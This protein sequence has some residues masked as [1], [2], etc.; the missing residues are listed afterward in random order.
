MALDYYNDRRTRA[1]YYPGMTEQEIKEDLDGIRIR[2]EMSGEP[3]IWALCNLFKQKVTLH[4]QFNVDTY[5]IIG[6]EGKYHLDHR[7]LHFSPFLNENNIKPNYLEYDNH[8][9]KY[10]TIYEILRTVGI[11][12][13]FYLN[14]KK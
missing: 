9:L 10:K 3:Q 13:L 12:T 5:G 2:N 8:S 6:E 1:I 11:S 4:T 14:L 7:G